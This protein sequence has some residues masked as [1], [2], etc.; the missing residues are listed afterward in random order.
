MKLAISIL[1]ALA[2]V[3]LFMPDSTNSMP[4]GPIKRKNNARPAVVRPAAPRTGR[5][6]VRPANLRRPVNLRRGKQ[7]SDVAA[8]PP[9]VE[10]DDAAAAA[11][12]EGEA[13]SEV[14]AWCDPTKEMG[15]WLNFV[16]MRKWCA[17]NGYTNFGPY[18]GV[19]AEGEDA[20]AKS[21]GDEVAQEVE[22]EEAPTQ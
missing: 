6:L 5:K 14:P 19:P 12:P 3:A 7:D 9:P 15:A 22:A 10:G 8:P 13:G 4:A 1:L 21:T 17:D 2:L 18:G 11:A 20:A 16:K